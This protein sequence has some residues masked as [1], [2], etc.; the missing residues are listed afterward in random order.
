MREPAVLVLKCFAFAH[1]TKP[2]RLWFATEKTLLSNFVLANSKETKFFQKRRSCIDWEPP[3]RNTDVFFPFY[4]L[5]S[6]PWEIIC[7]QFVSPQQISQILGQMQ[8]LKLPWSRWWRWR[9]LIRKHR[10]C[11]RPS[12]LSLPQPPDER[13]RGRTGPD[14]ELICKFYE[15]WDFSGFLVP[16]FQSPRC[17]VDFQQ[18]IPK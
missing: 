12:A 14:W 11:W 5:T 9:S 15:L 16:G 4:S 2:W 8:H 18:R 17:G 6:R 10:G 1:L 7:I 13:D 3:K